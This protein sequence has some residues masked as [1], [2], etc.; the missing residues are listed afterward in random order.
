MM[1][2]HESHDFPDTAFL[3]FPPLLDCFSE[4]VRKTG[5]FRRLAGKFNRYDDRTFLFAF[6][7]TLLYQLS[8]FRSVFE[9]CSK[10]AALPFASSWLTLLSPLA[11]R[12]SLV[13]GKEEFRVS[14]S[15]RRR[16]ALSPK[17]MSSSCTP[18]Y[19]FQLLPGSTEYVVPK[20]ILRQ[21]ESHAP[22]EAA[23]LATH[24][25]LGHLQH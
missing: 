4:G 16:R 6:H 17:E 15:S 18:F 23:V 24:A 20:L 2:L 22:R 8:S 1:F 7:A 9:R 25:A 12:N 3:G 13:A 19:W 21:W 14:R 10:S 5:N 11:S